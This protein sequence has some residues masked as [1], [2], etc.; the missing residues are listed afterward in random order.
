MKINNGEIMHE[1]P[2]RLRC[3]NWREDNA[4]IQIRARVPV[5][6][7]SSRVAGDRDYLRRLRAAEMAAW[8]RSGGDYLMSC[9]A[10]RM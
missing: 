3:S 4:P 7:M 8:E 5:V 2:F 1:I 9:S 6:Q 10:A